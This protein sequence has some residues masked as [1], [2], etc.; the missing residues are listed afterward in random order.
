MLECTTYKLYNPAVV[1]G[2]IPQHPESSWET[3]KSPPCADVLLAKK[4]KPSMMKTVAPNLVAFNT[5]AI[6]VRK[7]DLAVCAS[8]IKTRLRKLNYA[9]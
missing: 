7:A 8:I 1:G 4:H 6:V 3:M 5:K 9:A 2:L